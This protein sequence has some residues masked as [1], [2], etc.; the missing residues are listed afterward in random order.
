MRVEVYGCLLRKW[1][2][3]YTFFIDYRLQHLAKLMRQIEMSGY[4]ER[5]SDLHEQSFPFLHYQCCF[6]DIRPLHK[7]FV[8]L[9][10]IEQKRGEGKAF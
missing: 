8:P 5:K 10:N 1:I 3:K 6:V 2:I 7:L 4:V 9:N